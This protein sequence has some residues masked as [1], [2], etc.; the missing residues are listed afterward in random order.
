MKNSGVEKVMLN[1]QELKENKI[2]L[3][4]NGKIKLEGTPEKVAKAYEKLWE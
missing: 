3:I 1:G 2:K 4:D